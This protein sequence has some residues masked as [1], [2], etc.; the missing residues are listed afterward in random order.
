MRIAYVALHLEKKYVFGGVGRKIREH[1][2]IWNEMG[3]EAQFFLLTPDAID[4]SGIS[5]FQFGSTQKF[6]PLRAIEREISRSKSL[7]KLIQKVTEFQPDIIYLRYGLFTLPLPRLFQIAPVVLEVNTDDVIEYRHR[8]LFFYYL[9][10][11]TRGQIFGKASG[12]VP[13]SQE[14]VTRPS[15]NRFNK[16]VLVLSNG[17]DLNAVKPLPAPCNS[18]PRLAFVGIPGLDWNGEDK[19]IEFA[20]SVPDIQLDLVGF[21]CTDMPDESIPDNVVFH[22]LVEV[23]KVYEILSHADVTSGTLALHR[24]QLEENSAL[25]VRE[26]LALGIPIILGYYDT[27]IS[28]RDFD[29]VLQLPNQESNVKDNTEKI[30]DFVYHMVGKR[31][32]RE[33]ITPL[34]DQRIKEESRLA[35][36]EKILHDKTT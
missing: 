18:I 29:F 22:G 27:D 19:L 13:I 6:K 34:I 17:I 5:C 3:N 9:N 36:F 4:L 24:K 8:G 1:V 35:F 12:L 15:I 28:G 7:G 16:P 30:R 31:V 25:K 2:R 14:L 32:D 11:I 23:A 10:R 20:R 26:A 21:S 33:A